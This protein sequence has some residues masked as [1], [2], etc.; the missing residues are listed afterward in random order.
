MSEA[1]NTDE[2]AEPFEVRGTVKWFNTVKGFGFITPADETHDLFLHRSVLRDAGHE[3]LQPG[4]TVLCEVVRRD[5][6]L[7][8]TRFLDVDGSTA[9]SPSPITR[10]TDGPIYDA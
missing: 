6:G 7:Q 9:E 10:D 1:T 2:S 5:K 3:E 4:A 8:V